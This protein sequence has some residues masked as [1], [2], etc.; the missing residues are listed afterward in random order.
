[1]SNTEFNLFNE[2]EYFT[3]FN[4]NFSECE[5]RQKMDFLGSVTGNSKLNFVNKNLKLAKK[6]S[7]WGKSEGTFATPTATQKSIVILTRIAL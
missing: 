1:M 6:K 4:A 2:T 7:F 3:L 5:K